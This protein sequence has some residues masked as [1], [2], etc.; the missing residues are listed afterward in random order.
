[1]KPR[2][3]ASEQNYSVYDRPSS[4]KSRWRKQ[5]TSQHTEEKTVAD[6]K[7]RVIE[8]P[9]EPEKNTELLSDQEMNALAAKILKAEII[10]NEVIFSSSHTL[11]IIKRILQR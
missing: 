7:D 9:T 3:E 1:M 11:K 5:P 2:E 8:K 6:E 4:S 10:G